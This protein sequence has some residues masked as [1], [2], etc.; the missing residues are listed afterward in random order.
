MP[1]Q[2][3]KVEDCETGE[4]SEGQQV[5]FAAIVDKIT[6]QVIDSAAAKV[7]PRVVE[8]DKGIG[9][10]GELVGE[11]HQHGYVHLVLLLLQRK[12]RHEY[13]QDGEVQLSQETR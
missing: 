5:V 4:D 8:R 1:P 12:L 2:N 13:V 3:T 9:D 6:K 10:E 7:Y 11:D